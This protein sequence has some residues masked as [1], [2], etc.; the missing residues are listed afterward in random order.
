MS[1]SSEESKGHCYI[2]AWE[3]ASPLSAA[4]EAPLSH[5]SAMPALP[6]IS[7]PLSRHAPVYTLLR[8]IRMSQLRTRRHKS[9]EQSS[10]TR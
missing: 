4:I 9:K 6:P 2:D 3:A 7:Y 5:V 8:G 1:D 10:K